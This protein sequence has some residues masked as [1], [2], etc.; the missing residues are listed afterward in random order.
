MANAFRVAA[1]PATARAA[2]L[3]EIETVARE[4]GHRRA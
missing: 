2:I 3:S 1:L 4:I